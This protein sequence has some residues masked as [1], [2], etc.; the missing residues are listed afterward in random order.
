MDRWR[1]AAV[2]LLFG[3]A[4]AV[5]ALH[6][7]S[8]QA[9]ASNV[10]L[11]RWDI[12]AGYSYW[13][14]HGAL[15]G[16]A[17][18]TTFRAINVGSIYS[19]A[20]YFNRYAGAQLEVGLHPETSNDGAATYSLGPVFRLPLENMT[21]FAHALVGGAR[22]TGANLPS[23]GGTGYFYNK[24]TWGPA[25]TVGGGIDYQ[26]PFFEHHLALR[27][28]QADYQY[29]HESYGPATATSGGRA[30]LD[31]A[32][33][34]TG[35]V[36]HLGSVEPPKPV[37][38][39]CTAAPATVYPGD[40]VAISGVAANLNPKKPAS[41]HWSTSGGKISGSG[42]NASVATENLAPGTYT[43]VGQVSEGA[44]PTE[45]A[46]CK[47]TF[48][49][50]AYD[51]PTISCTATPATIKPGESVTIAS[52]AVSPQ[53]LPLTY[54]YSTSVGNISGTEATATLNTMNAAPGEI[55]V[56]CNVTDKVGHSASATTAIHVEA[57]PPP[58]APKTE[59]LCTASFARDKR[60][61]VRVDNEA[62]ACL[63][64]VA[65]ALQRSADAT[66]VLVG[67]AGD[68]ERHGDRLA[69]ERAVNTEE[70]LT[71]EKGIDASRIQLRS[72]DEQ[73]RQVETYL[74]P[75]GASFDQDV[76]GTKPVDLTNLH[77]NRH[78]PRTRK[79]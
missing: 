25:I 6:A 70:Y 15:Q 74:V 5:P 47:A 2:M 7:Q 22:V 51:P 79:K 50:K 36:L 73:A 12:F 32:R 38:Y 45:A 69:T 30:N 24:C 26:L 44:K 61:P 57:P 8:S 29:V 4:L 17:A 13:A 37:T 3:C 21:P 62:K 68:K 33:L 56:T 42:A 14:P 9:N 64:D 28:F 19:G 11:S 63:D 75:A 23:I 78:Y 16:T 48:T 18:D 53:N 72:S 66:L 46:E 1:R 58:P 60:R 55:T 52:S 31:V 34:S 41:Y 65:L 40:P 49:V 67:E 39:A 27:L 54:S 76:P 77:T 35:L 71:A 20:Y 59:K 43:V 10:N